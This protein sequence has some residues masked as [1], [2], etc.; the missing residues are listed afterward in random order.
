MIQD[1]KYAWRALLRPWRTT[2]TAVACLA[3]A[4]GVNATLF[5]V[6]D[7]LLLR[8][9]AHVAAPDGVM[10][11]RLGASA[12]ATRAAA[13]PAISYAHVRRISEQLAGVADIA[14]YAPRVFTL[15]EGKAAELLPGAIVS[16]SYFAV[17]G[18]PAQIGRL[19]DTEEDDVPGAAAVAVLSHAA[20]KNRFD[21]S[22]GAIGSTLTINGVKVSVIGVA[23]PGFTGIDLGEPE[24]WLNIGA[25][26]YPAFGG[27]SQFTDRT[28]WLQMI[29]RHRPG[30]SAASLSGAL[31]GENLPRYTSVRLP[32]HTLPLRAMFFS[33]QRGENPVPPWTIGITLAVLLLAC[34]TVANLL[35][36]QGAA[37]ASEM[38]IRG[39]LGASRSR[40][41]R[42]LLVENLMIAMAAGAGAVVFA[43]WSARIVQI[44]PVPAI[45]RFIDVRVGVF[46][47]SVAAVAT[48]LFG[49][50]P[51]LWTTRSDPAALLRSGPT[52]GSRGRARGQ[53]RL[54]RTGLQQQ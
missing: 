10:R 21:A 8:P 7:A 45:P 22:P 14:V 37:R 20:W 48:L 40:I 31:A 12:A 17:L 43:A 44:L 4:I 11:I 30:V 34:A 54:L 35:L 18:I 42:Q 6:I 9:P 16:A 15:G 39:S 23:P 47:F 1:V 25:A 52:G 33:E 41:R 3:L 46:A 49:L 27:P 13:G 5:G 32:L 53:H 28:F 24:L 38:A 36:A 26:Q 51:A 2:V 29:A 19:P 50:L